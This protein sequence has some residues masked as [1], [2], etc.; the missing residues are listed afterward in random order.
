MA[1]IVMIVMILL[2]GLAVGMYVQ[3]NTTNALLEQDLIRLKM[4]YNDIV[5]ENMELRWKIQNH[6]PPPPPPRGRPKLRNIKNER[7]R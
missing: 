3:V 2:V 5:Q 7:P 1:S 6:V 4:K